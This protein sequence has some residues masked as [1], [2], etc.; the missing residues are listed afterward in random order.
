MYFSIP[1]YGRRIPER[2]MD[3][4][5]QAS[6]MSSVVFVKIRRVYRMDMTAVITALRG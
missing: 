1:L 4:A 5:A 3:E 2:R 6:I